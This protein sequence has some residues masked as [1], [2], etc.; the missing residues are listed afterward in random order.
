M[1]HFFSSQCVRQIGLRRLIQIFH[2]GG[3]EFRTLTRCHVTGIYIQKCSKYLARKKSSLGNREFRNEKKFLRRKCNCRERSLL[4][5]HS[6]AVQ[7]NKPAM[8][9]IFCLPPA[10]SK[11]GFYYPASKS[12]WPDE[13]T[14]VSHVLR[15]KENS[16]R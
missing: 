7:S 15:R 4:L 2:I 13:L 12:F 9:H 6:R 10:F 11:R 5:L 3:K 1:R 8:A 14:L 16:N